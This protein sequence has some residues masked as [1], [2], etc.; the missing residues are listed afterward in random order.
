MLCQIYYW[1]IVEFASYARKVD[2]D[3]KLEAD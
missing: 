2:E 1:E 3:I